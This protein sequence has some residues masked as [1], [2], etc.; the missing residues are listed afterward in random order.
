[1][2]LPPECPAKSLN[3]CLDVFQ[4]NLLG[5]G[6]AFNGFC[7]CMPVGVFDV[8]AHRDVAGESHQR[9]GALKWLG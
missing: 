9:H 7:Q 1:M 4:A 3:T 2:A 6:A 5:N 8:H